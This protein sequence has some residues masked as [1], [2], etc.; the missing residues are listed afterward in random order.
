[1][2]IIEG[3]EPF[4]NIFTEADN[5]DIQFIKMRTSWEEIP[6]TYSLS[7]HEAHQLGTLLIKLANE[8][9]YFKGFKKDA[10]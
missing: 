6:I 3:D 8:T 1:M 9:D 7:P 2:K 10:D 4:I 5:Y